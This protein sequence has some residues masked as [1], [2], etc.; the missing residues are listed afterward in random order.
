MTGRASG[1]AQRAC[2]IA[3]NYGDLPAQV[4]GAAASTRASPS[5]CRGLPSS[6]TL[7]PM[8]VLI[9][10][11]SPACRAQARHAL[12]VVCPQLVERT[13]DEAVDVAEAHTGVDAL[14]ALASTPVDL[15]LV[16]LNLPVVHGL[17]LIA[18]W[19]RRAAGG[20]AVVVSTEPSTL[21]RERARALGSVAFCDKP[22]SPEALSAALAS[23]PG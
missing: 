15:L 6:D 12:E 10:D 21:D 3:R 2:D 17:E 11:D 23:L 14:R 13:A 20:R 7:A 4:D 8:R 5:G 18:F 9:V 1:L 22:V 19:R 16:D